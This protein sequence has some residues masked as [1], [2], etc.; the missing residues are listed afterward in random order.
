MARPLSMTS[1]TAP[2]AIKTVSVRLL[3]ILP[4]HVLLYFGSESLSPPPPPMAA[5]TR[6]CGERRSF[7]TRVVSFSSTQPSP[8]SGLP[9][10]VCFLVLGSP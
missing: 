4:H 3:L 1:Y 6:L 2:P 5:K 10:A 7:P 8:S 9:L